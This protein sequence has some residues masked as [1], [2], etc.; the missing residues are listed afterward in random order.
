MLLKQFLWAIR[1]KYTWKT[2][3]AS[4]LSR[5][6]LTIQSLCPRANLFSFFS[7]FR[8]L[9]LPS[10]PLT[11]AL[12]QRPW[13]PGQGKNYQSPGVG[14]NWVLILPLSPDSDHLRD[15]NANFLPHI[16]VFS[17]VLAGL[18]FT[19]LHSDTGCPSVCSEYVLL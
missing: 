11:K 6:V 14:Q 2:L 17:P 19:C 4:C 7:V 13:G 18:S 15:G 1:G 5:K 12:A 9:P 8:C 16:H 10:S 3:P